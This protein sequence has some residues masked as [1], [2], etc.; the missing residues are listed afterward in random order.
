M[1]LEITEEQRQ[2]VL[3]AL[4]RLAA[5]RPGFDFALNEVAIKMDNLKEGRAL[6]YDQFRKMARREDPP[7]MWSR[8]EHEDLTSR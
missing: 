2:L 3:L 7:T 8:L 1:V 6:M 5:E 4:G